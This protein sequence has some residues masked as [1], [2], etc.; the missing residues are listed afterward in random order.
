LSGA[1]LACYTALALAV[2]MAAYLIWFDRHF[3]RR[4]PSLSELVRSL[5]SNT[6][7]L[8][9]AKGETRMLPPFA[10]VYGGGF[11]ISG[12]SLPCIE[13]QVFD[14]ALMEF[15]FVTVY[16]ALPDKVTFE[17][18]TQDLGKVE[19]KPEYSAPFYKLMQHLYAY[20]PL[21]AEP[22]EVRHV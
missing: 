8:E 16:V 10:G 21:M 14:D 5:V 13:Y 9:L 17:T 7:G 2:A 19:T 12:N 4:R 18:R 11:R 15:V 1:I 3:K 6:A 20:F 22:K